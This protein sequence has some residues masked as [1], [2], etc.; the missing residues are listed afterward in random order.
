LLWRTSILI[1]KL[2]ESTSH[3]ARKCERIVRDGRCW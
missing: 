2:G 1:G 3:H